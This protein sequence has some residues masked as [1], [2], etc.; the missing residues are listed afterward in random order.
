MEIG[1]I[2][3]LVHLAW[4]LPL[5]CTMILLALRELVVSEKMRMIHSLN[6]TIH[7]LLGFTWVRKQRLLNLEF[8]ALMPFVGVIVLLVVCI[9][10]FILLPIRIIIMR[11]R[12][13]VVE[14]DGIYYECDICH[15]NDTAGKFSFNIPHSE[16]LPFTA[17]A[18]MVECHNRLPSTQFKFLKRNE[19]IEHKITGRLVCGM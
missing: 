9:D 13:L 15:Y 2:A 16:S 14:L 11:R 7:N 4:I 6:F 5:Q 1:D 17:L 18:Q 10:L 12:L 19:I 8:L 3:L